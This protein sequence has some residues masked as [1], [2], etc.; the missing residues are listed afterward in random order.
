MYATIASQIE[1]VNTNQETPY[2]ERRLSQQAL[3]SSNSDLQTNPFSQW[4]SPFS[5]FSSSVPGSSIVPVNIPLEIQNETE[6]EQP[7][8]SEVGIVTPI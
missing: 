5:L 7:R 3:I 6:G 1:N 2:P 8:T 4:R